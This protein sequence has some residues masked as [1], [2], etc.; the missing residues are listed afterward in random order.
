VIR[1]G[2]SGYAYPEWRGTFYPERLPAGR[3]LPF[4]AERFATVEINATFYRMPTAGTV[5]AWAGATPDGFVFSLK[6]PQ[7]I[8]HMRRLLDVDEPLRA[9]CDAAAGLGSRAGPLLFQLPPTFRRE[10]GR[11][12]DLLVRIPPGT[13]C[14]VEFRH[15]SWFADDVYAVLGRHGAA[16]CIADTEAGTTPEVATA[17]WGY[18]RLRDAGYD[19][20]ALDGW[21]RRIARPEWTDVYVYFKHE[22]SAAGPALAARLIERLPR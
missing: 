18:L 10:P 4:Y 11:L 12:A 19:D 14:A 13:R 22:E 8:T 20:A 17:P 21:A 1:V 6:A 15:P 5:A 2:T 16:L 7:R 3:M 9:F